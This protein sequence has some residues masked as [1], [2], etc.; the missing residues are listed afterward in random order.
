MAAKFIRPHILQFQIELPSKGYAMSNAKSSNHNFKQYITAP[1]IPVLVIEKVETAVPLAKALVA[2]GLKT[3]EVTLRTKNAFE[4]IRIIKNEV[5]DAII[6]AGTVMNAKQADTAQEMGSQFIV[7]PGT[8]MAL[9]K[10]AAQSQLHILPGATTVSELMLLQENNYFFAKFFPAEAA[11]G[12][13]FLKSVQ[14]PL[15]DMMFCPTGGIMLSNVGEYLA[16]KNVVCVGGSWV[17]PQNLIEA[18]DWNA[19]T[20]LASEASQL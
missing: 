2:G 10:H 6:G 1:V 19:I 12:V 9:L 5:P 17:A 8:S 16:L 14:S 18:C 11:G 3:L 20:K 15:A 4:A 7:S 13:P